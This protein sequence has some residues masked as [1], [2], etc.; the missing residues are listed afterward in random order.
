MRR[1]CREIE[2][3][4]GE[5]RGVLSAHVDDPLCVAE[6]AFEFLGAVR[7]DV[8]CVGQIGALVIGEEEDWRSKATRR[9]GRSSR[10]SDGVVSVRFQAVGPVGNP[11]V[12]SGHP[13][14]GR[15]ENR[16]LEFA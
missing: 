2:P 3:L 8:S 6:V 7:L 11:E 5:L 12:S 14:A 13:G 9:G 4:G 15:H 16:L 10:V 1:L